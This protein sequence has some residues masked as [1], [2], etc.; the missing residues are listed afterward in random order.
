MAHGDFE[1][2]IGEHVAQVGGKTRVVLDEQD[3][4]GFGHGGGYRK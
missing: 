2:V 3:V 4:S 1:T